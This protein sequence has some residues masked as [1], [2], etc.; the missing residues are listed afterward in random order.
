MVGP[1]IR[2][3]PLPTLQSNA[4]NWRVVRLKPAAEKG[5]YGQTASRR[6]PA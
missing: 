3:R 6:N 1:K 5:A 4:K 2:R